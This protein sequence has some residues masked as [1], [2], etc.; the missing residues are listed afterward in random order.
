MH[1]YIPQQFTVLV[2]GGLLTIHFVKWFSFINWMVKLWPALFLQNITMLYYL[3][4]SKNISRAQLSLE[5]EYFRILAQQDRSHL[6][7]FILKSF[8]FIYIQLW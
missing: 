5:L 2:A 1:G 8:W 4:W 7:F 3:V 6:V